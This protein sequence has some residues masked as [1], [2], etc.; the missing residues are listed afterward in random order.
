MA[1]PNKE[2]WVESLV[3]LVIARARVF[4][5]DTRTWERHRFALDAHDRDVPV[6][7][8][9]AIRFCAQAALTRAS[10]DI[11]GTCFPALDYRKLARLAGDCLVG[12]DVLGDINASRGRTRVLKLV[13]KFL[14]REKFL[15]DAIAAPGGASSRE[16]ARVV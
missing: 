10:Y 9:D 2:Q 5:S 12:Y 7:S 16:T 14:G 8:P 15:S 4:I 3:Q 13:D 11:V 1:Y 6:T